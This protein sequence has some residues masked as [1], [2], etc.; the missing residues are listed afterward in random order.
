MQSGGVMMSEVLHTKHYAKDGVGGAD[1]YCAACHHKSKGTDVTEGCRTC[2]GEERDGDVLS[3]KEAQHRTCF[4]CHLEVNN[5][6]TNFRGATGQPTDQ[7]TSCLGC[8]ENRAEPVER[9]H[10]LGE[11]FPMVPDRLSCI[12]W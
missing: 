6:P 12:N 3:V 9:W 11:R 4:R 2:H 5:R 8:H 1:I 7:P 10:G